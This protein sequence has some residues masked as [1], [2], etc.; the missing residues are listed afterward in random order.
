M[1]IES[2]AAGAG[3]E[4]R[5]DLRAVAGLDLGALLQRARMDGAGTVLDLGN[6]APLTLAGVS[7]TALHADDFALGG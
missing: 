4:D 7:L 5:L 3:S 2:F 6:G 1:A